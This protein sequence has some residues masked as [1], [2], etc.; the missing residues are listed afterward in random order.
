MLVFRPEKGWETLPVMTLT[1]HKNIRHSSSVGRKW[2][3]NKSGSVWGSCKFTNPVSDIKVCIVT[4]SEKSWG[5]E[6]RWQPEENGHWEPPLSGHR[7]RA[8]CRAWWR[9][10]PSPRETCR[11]AGRRPGPTVMRSS[12]WR[13]GRSQWG[14]SSGRC[15]VSL[16]LSLSSWILLPIAERQELLRGDETHSLNSLDRT[17]FADCKFQFLN[18]KLFIYLLKCP[19]L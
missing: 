8:P 17:L 4:M 19:S 11:P 9:D 12:S 2:G 14:Q 18:L 15:Q 3:E 6:T 7:Y 16:S 1:C 13:R 10:S 5:P